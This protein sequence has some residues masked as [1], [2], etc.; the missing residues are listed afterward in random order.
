[1]LSIEFRILKVFSKLR[2]SSYFQFAVE[3]TA[4]LEF[5]SKPVSGRCL[6]LMQETQENYHF[7]RDLVAKNCAEV[8][9]EPLKFKYHLFSPDSL[10]E[11]SQLQWRRCKQT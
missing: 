4:Q 1:M 10:R 3:E 8:Q 9:I 2:H 7:K 5:S 11:R 6:N